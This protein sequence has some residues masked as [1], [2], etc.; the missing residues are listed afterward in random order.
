MKALILQKGDEKENDILKHQ[1]VLSE[2]P[3][4]SLNPDNDDVLIRL[5]AAAFNHR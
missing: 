4:P 1:A 3:L 5:Q 2:I